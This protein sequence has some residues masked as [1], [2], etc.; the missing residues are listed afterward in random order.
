MINQQRAENASFK[1]LQIIG[2]ALPAGAALFLLVGFMLN[3]DKLALLP[4]DNNSAVCYIALAFGVGSSIM[5]NVIFNGILQ[6]IDTS[7]LAKEKFPKYV[8]A[9][10]I[11]LSLIEGA[12]LFNAVAFL[13]SAC[14]LNAGMAIGLIALM[15]SIRP[16]RQKTID[17]LKVYYPDTLD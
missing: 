7:V 2:F 4:D 16:Q 12:A 3:Q 17:D 6:K 13:L 14:L 15:L 8:A 10:I 9:Y 5:S 1:T 11:R